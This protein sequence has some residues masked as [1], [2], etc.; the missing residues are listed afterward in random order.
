MRDAL[1]RASNNP[2][3]KR[4]IDQ[5]YRQGAKVG[6]GG[7]ADALRDEL[8]RGATILNA[9]HAIKAMERI[10]ELQRLINS[11]QLSVEDEATAQLIIENLKR[12]LRGSR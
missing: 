9:R 7:T 5:L 3:L 11:G 1:L 4:A 10:R 6:D 2:A 8:A 12:A